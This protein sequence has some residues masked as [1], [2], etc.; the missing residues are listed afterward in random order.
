MKNSA[1]AQKCGVVLSDG[2]EEMANKIR[3]WVAGNMPE[4]TPAQVADQALL[5][6]NGI[7]AAWGEPIGDF[8]SAWGDGGM[9]AVKRQAARLR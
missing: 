2:P 1:I 6:W 7:F 5:A 8:A 4:A 9:A 3:R